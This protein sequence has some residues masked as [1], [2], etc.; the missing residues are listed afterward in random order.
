MNR[1][2]YYHAKRNKKNPKPYEL[3]ITVSLLH[4]EPTKKMII[5]L[6]PRAVQRQ[7]GISQQPRITNTC[8]TDKNT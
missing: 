7:V 1:D 3:R 2:S 4:K 8:H 5:I 6:T